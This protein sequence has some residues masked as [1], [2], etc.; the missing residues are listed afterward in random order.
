MKNLFYLLALSFYTLFPLSVIA[1]SPPVKPVVITQKKGS[2]NYNPPPPPPGNPPG[3]RRYGGAKRGSCPEVKPPLTALV[4]ITQTGSVKNVW[5]LTSQ[6]RP[7]LIFYTPYA[8][9]SGYATEL[10]FL[11]DETKEP[12]Y[13]TAI[14]LPS[15]PGLIN[16]S[17]P[18]TVSP[19]TVGKRYR[20]YFNIY[21]DQQKQSPPIYVEGVILRQNLTP[22]V[23][24]QLKTAP[25]NQKFV[26]YGQ[27]GFW[28]DALNSLAQLRQ[29]QPKDKT[30]QTQW[31][32]LL[33]EVGLLEIATQSF[34]EK[35]KK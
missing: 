21:C 17:L 28:Y 15:K 24:N 4:P 20:W 34:E 35:A 6:E 13:E 25:A 31:Q 1:Q 27:N 30:L 29:Q 12:I 33:D 23:I 2:K 16:I 7:T 32:D 14:A 9:D 10:S 22:A 19:L 8:S 11:D 26:I 18:N 5:G 3:G